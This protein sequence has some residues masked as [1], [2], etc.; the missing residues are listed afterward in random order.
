[1]VK[2]D[3][4][5]HGVVAF[6]VLSLDIMIISVILGGLFILLV[7]S[8]RDILSNLAAEAYLRVRKPFD[9]G[10]WIRIGD[11]EGRVRVIG[12]IDTEL[13]TPEGE[14]VVIPNS[15]FLNR[16]TIN[17]SRAVATYVD[18]KLTI[19]NVSLKQLEENVEEAL[20]DIRSELLGEP[21]I[22]SINEREGKAEVIVSLPVVNLRKMRWLINRLSKSFYRQGIEVEIE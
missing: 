5:I 6:S 9:E 7:I 22:L 1:L 19:S 16:L 17:K 2:I 18:L 20:K 3:G 4:E 13:I 10:D 15:V 21:E 14:R 8:V 12:S 11:V